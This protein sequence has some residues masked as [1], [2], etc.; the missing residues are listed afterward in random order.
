M[1]G[2][3]VRVALGEV[4]PSGTVGVCPSGTVEVCPSRT[5]GVGP[6]GIFLLY[7]SYVHI[8]CF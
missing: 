4:R 6:S 8:D 5:V 2:G 3:F 7:S 1:G